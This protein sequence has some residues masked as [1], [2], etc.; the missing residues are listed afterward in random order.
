MN[1]TINK[2]PLEGNHIELCSL[3]IISQEVSF[4]SLHRCWVKNEMFLRTRLH[5]YDDNGERNSTMKWVVIPGMSTS[6]QI[7]PYYALQIFFKHVLP[8]AIRRSWFAHV[9]K[10]VKQI[11]KC[12]YVSNLVILYAVDSFRFNHQ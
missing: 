10:M 1:K 6:T 8:A 11:H 5:G 7:S 9:Q 12:S 2:Y 3:R 4:Y